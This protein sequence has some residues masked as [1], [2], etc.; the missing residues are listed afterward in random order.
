M[1]MSLDPGSHEA[2]INLRGPCKL[3]V[4]SDGSTVAVVEIPF[5]DVYK[6]VVKGKDRGLKKGA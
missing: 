1:E 5:G 3:D 6:L 4:T 2:V